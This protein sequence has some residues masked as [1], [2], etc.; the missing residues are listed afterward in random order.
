MS[1]PKEVLTLE[2]LK[3]FA[4]ISL[5]G[6]CFQLVLQGEEHWEKRREIFTVHSVT[7]FHLYTPT[8]TEHH[9]Y[10]EDDGIGGLLHT[11]E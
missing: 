7:N 2:V 8:Y 4:A 9:R 11:Y 1:L 10:S 3:L 6:P 5:P